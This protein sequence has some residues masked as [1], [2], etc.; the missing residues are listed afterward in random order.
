MATLY[1]A[2]RS[3]HSLPSLLRISNYGYLIVFASCCFPFDSIRTGPG[4]SRKPPRFFRPVRLHGAKDHAAIQWWY[5]IYKIVLL[6]GSGSMFEIT[7]SG[8]RFE[9]LEQRQVGADMLSPELRAQS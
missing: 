3:F 2:A 5:H 7:G 1:G 8:T 9:G 6:E 4:Q